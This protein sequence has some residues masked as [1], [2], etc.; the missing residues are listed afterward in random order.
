MSTAAYP[1]RKRVAIVGGGVAG[2]VAAHVL[3]N[4]YAVTIFDQNGYL[5]GHTNTLSIDHGPDAGTAVDTGF[6]VFNEATYPMFIA[7]LEELGVASRETDMSFGFHCR[8]S[9]L[10]YAGNTL[11]G[12]FAQRSNLVR[13]QFYRFLFEIGRFCRQATIDLVQ[14]TAHGTLADYVAGHNFMPFMV[15]NYLQPM[16]AAIWSTPSGQVAQFPALPF[17]SFFKNHGLL[18]LRNRPRWRTVCGGSH[19]Y[20]QAFRNRFVGAIQLKSSID[21]IM[22]SEEGVHLIF[23]DGH[24]E[25][26][27]RLIIATHADQALRLL[28]DPTPDERRLLGAWQYETNT[29]V[30]HTDT[31]VLPPVER[32][33]ACWNFQRDRQGDQH[34]QVHVSYWMNLLQGLATKENYMVTLNRPEVYRDTQVIARM[35]YQHPT[36]TEASMATQPLLPALNG[37]RRTWYCGSYFGYGFHEDAVRSSY[38]AT[39]HLKDTP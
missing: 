32:A 5:G 17:L 30:L 22:R 4:E 12:L 29:A 9:G 7:F 20:V 2:I 15:E 24:R 10:L 14:G 6:I 19:S 28:D 23:T 25:T 37:V 33:W 1:H 38:Q 18:N 27:D 13:P 11:N 36:Y 34:R 3:Q 35:E 26:F 21:R 39:A 16:A 31:S 8:A